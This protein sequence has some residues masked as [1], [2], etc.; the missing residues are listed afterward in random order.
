VRASTYVRIYLNLYLRVSVTLLY[1]VKGRQRE[2]VE[3]EK[4]IFECEW[5]VRLCKTSSGTTRGAG[6]KYTVQMVSLPARKMYISRIKGWHQFQG[7]EEEEEEHFLRF[8]SLI[9]NFTIF[10][11]EIATVQPHIFYTNQW[12]LSPL[13][14]GVNNNNNNNNST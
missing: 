6:K 1:P 5:G 12:P 13:I 2:M 10:L 3:S 9:S 8:P 4:Q 7:E 11:V 14:C